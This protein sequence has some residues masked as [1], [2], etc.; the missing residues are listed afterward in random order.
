MLNKLILSAHETV[1]Q[2]DPGRETLTAGLGP[3][4]QYTISLVALIVIGIIVYFTRRRKK[5]KNAS[6]DTPRMKKN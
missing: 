2:N 5:R 6:E 3:I 1:I 4:Q